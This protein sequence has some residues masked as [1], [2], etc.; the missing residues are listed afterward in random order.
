MMA[1][2]AT[3]NALAEAVVGARETR[4]RKRGEDSSAVTED[5]AVSDADTLCD[6]PV[7]PHSITPQRCLLA[8]P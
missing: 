8:R 7:R 1:E 5:R 3:F 4:R 2:D 6:S